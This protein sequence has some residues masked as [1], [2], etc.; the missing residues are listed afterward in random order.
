MISINIANKDVIE[1]SEGAA[2]AIFF[3]SLGTARP[4][5]V[6]PNCLMDKVMI[7]LFLLPIET[8]LALNRSPIAVYW[9]L[10]GRPRSQHPGNVSAEF[11]QRFIQ[12]FQATSKR[13]EILSQR[14]RGFV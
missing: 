10:V 12:I 11:P 4:V 7:A 14:N 9:S 6:V 13:G 1:F 5:T 3:E 8:Q 2:S